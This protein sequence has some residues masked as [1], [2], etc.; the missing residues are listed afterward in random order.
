[1]GAREQSR[2]SLEIAEPRPDPRPLIFPRSAALIGVSER[3]SP[4]VIANV[5]GKG[6]QV[7][8]VHPRETAIGSL[9]TLA[10]IAAVRPTPELAFLLVGHRRIEA[11]LD[12]ALAA[13]VRAFVVPGLGNEAGAEGSAVAARVAKRALDVGAVAVGPNCMGV[14]VPQAA[15]FWIGTVPASFLPGHVAAVVQSGSIGEALLALGPRVGFRCVISSGGESVTDVA[16]YCRFFAGDDAT[17]VVGLFLE[18]VRRP[19]AFAASLQLLAEA[20]KP[21]V[22]LKVGRTPGGAR[23]VLAHSGAVVGS[24]QAFSAMLRGY[25]VIEVEDF[26]DFVEVLEVLGRRRRPVG[27]RLGG[28][29]NSGGEGALLADHAEAA[30]LPFALLSSELSRRLTVAFPNYVVPQNPVDAWAIDETDKV[31]PGTL[32]LL[33]GSGEIDILVAQVDQ[34]QFLGEPEAANALLITRA[35]ADAVEGTGIFPAIASVQACD[36]T[37]AVAELAR[38]R[39]VAMLRGSR[40]AMRALA[41]VAGWLPRHPPPPG[42]G[43]TSNLDGLLEPG[44]LS[45]YDSGLLLERYGVRVGPRRRARTA[46]EAA[47][48][49]VELGFPVVVKREGSAHK[50]REGGVILGLEDG[51]SVARAVERLGGTVLVAAQLGGQVEVFCGMTRDPDWGPVLAI[52]RGGTSVEHLPGIRSCIAPIAIDEAR[53]LVRDTTVISSVVSPAAAEAIAAVVVALGRIAAEHPE[54]TA[55]DV[56][57][58]IVDEHGAVAVDALV[59]VG[60]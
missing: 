58:L 5:T 48:A 22:C 31:F 56:N 54:I 39:D 9:E 38:D 40:N 17:R 35:L 59:V 1:M 28:V 36:P 50:S 32:Q 47:R 49:A 55:V 3:T 16:D 11:A 7:T 21:V 41:A 43:P 4:E 23:A 45:E 29:S 60:S 52:G 24:D 27:R 14:A 10:A 19:A 53:R 37:P 30:G 6:I 12:A 42:R 46:G 20:G 33:A 57:P 13:G 34:S 15:S 18:S 25:G 26:P 44:A 2:A 8:A 51:A